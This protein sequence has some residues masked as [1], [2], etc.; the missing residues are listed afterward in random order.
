MQLLPC[1]GDSVDE[2]LL[3]V[4]FFEF[5]HDL[6]LRAFPE[7]WWNHIIDALV[8]V[9]DELSFLYRDIDQDPVGLLCIIHLQNPRLPDKAASHQIRRILQ[10]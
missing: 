9:D 10:R 7:V 5:S 4:S 2:A 3:V 1:L 6:I 8:T